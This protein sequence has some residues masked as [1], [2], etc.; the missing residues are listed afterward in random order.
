MTLP[1]SSNSKVKA[2]ASSGF[3]SNFLVKLNCAVVA[4]GVKVLLN[5]VST[6]VV[7]FPSASTPFVD[8][9]DGAV[10][11]KVWPDLVTVTVTFASIWS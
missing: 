7:A 5:S 4:P 9:Y 1:F 8:E 3:P 2:S 10:E 11:T 6:P